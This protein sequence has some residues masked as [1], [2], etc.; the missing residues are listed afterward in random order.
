MLFA[1]PNDVLEAIVKALLH[2]DLRFLNKVRQ[3]GKEVGTLTQTCK[4]ARGFFRRE[5]TK[6]E[7][8][9][10]ELDEEEK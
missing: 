2:I 9:G 3:S 4:A 6:T 10:R 7:V 8:G 1:L 5:S